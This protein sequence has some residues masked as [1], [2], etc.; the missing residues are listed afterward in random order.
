MGMYVGAY[1][2]TDVHT[3]THRPPSFHLQDPRGSW[4]E[5]WC[6]DCID[7]SSSS[8]KKSQLLTTRETDSLTAYMLNAAAAGKYTDIK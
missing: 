8:Q 5:I 3:D 2:H 7:S 6:L 4:E 1:V